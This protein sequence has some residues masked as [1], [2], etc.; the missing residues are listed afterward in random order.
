MPA[1]KHPVRIGTLAI[2]LPMGWTVLLGLLLLIGGMGIAE[3]VVRVPGLRPYLAPPM[4]SGHRQIGVK[5]DL[6]DRLQSAGKSPDCYLIG[7][8]MVL[9]GIEPEV[10]ARKYT[11]ATGEQITCFNFGLQGLNIR[12]AA[13]LAEIL[14]AH[15]HPRLIIYGTSFRDFAGE[16]GFGMGIPWSEY[17]MGHGSMEGAL[18][19]GLL[20]Y[21]TLLGYAEG[22]AASKAD[23][24]LSPYGFLAGDAVGDVEDAPDG[25]TRHYEAL[26]DYQITSQSLVDLR[27]L[28]ALN[29][30][31]TRVVVIEMPVPETTLSF[32]GGG[33][34]D[35]RL[36]MDTIQ[37][38]TSSQGV[39]FWP[40]MNASLIP[41]TGWINATHMNQSGA[42]IF[43]AWLAAQLASA[44]GR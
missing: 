30:G 21:R 17:Q 14:A 44:G 20:S 36:F 37:A 16:F 34:A 31:Q 15:A 32:L 3:V 1:Q 27:R 8:S 4:V 12:G 2:T 38:E 26:A 10:L 29:S 11:E 13:D 19:S 25:M 39:P 9:R 7:S 33:E 35:Y 43:S 23:L 42:T 28:L 41:D 6:L 22:S 24:G 18:E 5:L 40:T